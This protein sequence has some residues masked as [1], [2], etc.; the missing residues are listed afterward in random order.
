[1]HDVHPAQKTATKH[2]AVAVKPLDADCW[3]EAMVGMEGP[4]SPAAKA[5]NK[6]V[7]TYACCLCH[8]LFLEPCRDLTHAEV[9]RAFAR[10]VFRSGALPLVLRSDQGIEFKSVLMTEFVALLGVRR[11]LGAARRP[12]EQGTV[13][14]AHQET[15]KILGDAARGRAS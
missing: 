15:Q 11:R 14:R 3:E 12:M 7:A 5:G 8:A 4:S 9:R 13:E 1:M 10:R 6:Y 2:D